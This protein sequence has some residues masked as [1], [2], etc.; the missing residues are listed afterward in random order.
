MVVAKELNEKGIDITA[1]LQPLL[2]EFKDLYLEELPPKL[3]P[4]RNI[5]HH[6]D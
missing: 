4:L 6:I 1:I 5:K 2:K 3:S